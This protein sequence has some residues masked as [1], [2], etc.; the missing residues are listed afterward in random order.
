MPCMH[1]HMHAYAYAYACASMHAY[2]CK[3]M[4]MGERLQNRCGYPRP[5]KIW[6]RFVYFSCKAMSKNKLKNRD[7]PP[8]F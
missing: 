7:A 4:H 1:I 6:R 8:D 3:C 2:A 5:P